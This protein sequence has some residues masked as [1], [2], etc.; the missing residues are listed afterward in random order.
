M[1]V[2]AELVAFA[3]DLA[4]VAGKVILQYRSGEVWW[5][6]IGASQTVVI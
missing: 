5:G 3:E 6:G 1:D 2:P 4:D